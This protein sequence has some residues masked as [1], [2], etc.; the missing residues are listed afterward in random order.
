[1]CSTY[2]KKYVKPL[3]KSNE[4]ALLLMAVIYKSKCRPSISNGFSSRSLEIFPSSVLSAP[5]NKSSCPFSSLTTDCIVCRMHGGHPDLSH[6]YHPPS[7][8]Q[9]N[10]SL[11]SLPQALN[12]LGN[13]FQYL[14]TSNF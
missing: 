13:F 5:L 14:F 3:K 10:F 8:L 1:M 2:S 4:N 12:T 7:L 9:R 6:H 11:T